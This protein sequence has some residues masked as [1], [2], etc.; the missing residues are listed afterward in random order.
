M[1]TFR[2]KIIKKRHVEIYNSENLIYKGRWDDLPLQENI[3]IDKS[4]FYFNDPEPCYIHR[5][6]VRI[7]LLAE[8]EAEINNNFH[9]I[10][11][12]WLYKLSVLTGISHITRV[13]FLEK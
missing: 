6:A 12:Q 11:Q 9:T 10:P 4:I 2:N 13:E 8:L 7:R 5:D 1:F 3:I